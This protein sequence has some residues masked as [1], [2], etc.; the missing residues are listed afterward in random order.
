MDL[1]FRP[2]GIWPGKLSTKR[3]RST[4]R[5][6]YTATL[7]LLDSELHHLSARN[8]VL[9][10]ALT[11]ED[12]RLDGRPRAGSKSSHPGVIL[13]FD[14]KHGP[15]KY[16]CDTFE[17]WEDNVR[18]IA[19]SLEN[20]RAVDRYGVTRR[21]EQYSGW[22]ALPAPTNG[23]MDKEQ[24]LSFIRRTIGAAS[25]RPTSKD[26]LDSMYRHAA[27]ATHPDRGGNPDDFKRLQ[28]AKEALGL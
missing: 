5:V 18:A 27:M 20:L 21:G 1:T 4:F 8:V 19:L 13:A 24:A 28:Q 9:Q 16:P 23:A 25:A 26:D 14:S 7:T 10:V 15:L 2:I 6:G 17:R 12:I 22:T 11:E 3:K